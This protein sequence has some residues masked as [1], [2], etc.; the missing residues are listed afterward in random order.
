MSLTDIQKSKIRYM[1]SCN[2][3]IEN[4]ARVAEL[5][6]E[7]VLI[8]VNNFVATRLPLLQQEKNSI[9]Q[10]LNENINNLEQINLLLNLL[11]QKE[12]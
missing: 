9:E 1:T 8:E 7:E 6:D 10:L 4:M 5:S 2:P 11:E 3:T 12:S